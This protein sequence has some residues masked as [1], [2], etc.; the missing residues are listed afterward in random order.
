MYPD[1]MPK[2]EMLPGK[3]HRKERLKCTKGTINT[4][5]VLNV[6]G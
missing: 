5:F 4:M 6:V 1:K 2:D 3:F